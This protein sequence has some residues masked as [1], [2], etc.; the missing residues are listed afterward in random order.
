[1]PNSRLIKIGFVVLGFPIAVVRGSADDPA[2]QTKPAVAGVESLAPSGE[3]SRQSSAGISALATTAVD[4]ARRWEAGEVSFAGQWMTPDE[5]ARFLNQDRSDSAYQDRRKKTA[6]TADG[7]FKLAQWCREHDMPE[8]YR[9]HLIV[10][11]QL[12]PRDTRAHKA[13]GLVRHEGIWMSDADLAAARTRQ[14]AALK[15]YQFWKKELSE[16]RAGLVSG[17]L[18]VRQNAESELRKIRDPYAIPAMEEVSSQLQDERIGGI[19]VETLGQILHKAATGSLV[20]HAVWHNVASVR[21]AAIEQLRH[22]DQEHYVGDLIHLMRPAESGEVWITWRGGQAARVWFLQDYDRNYVIVN[23]VGVGHGRPDTMEN[24]T[25]Q[26][27]TRFDIVSANN[28]FRMQ[29]AY[30]ALKAVTGEDFGSDQQPWIQWLKDLSYVSP[31]EYSNPTRT[32]VL[33][34]ENVYTPGPIGYNQ[35]GHSCFVAGTPVW[36]ARGLVAIDHIQLGD[37]VLSKNV[38]TGE[39]GYQ[40]VIDRTIRRQKPTV[41]LQF[42]GETIGV[43]PRHPIWTPERDWVRA[44][45]LGPGDLVSTSSGSTPVETSSEGQSDYVYN[46]VVSGTNTYFVGRN[47]ILAHDITPIADV[48][49]ASAVPDQAAD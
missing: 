31:G 29:N 9:A 36:T 28:R 5:V 8:L 25:V 23:S 11:A 40:P 47:R 38:E 18:E 32:T 19:V 45:D 34:Y 17:D 16:I 33:S 14:A 37:L 21:G 27:R 46:L 49:I 30:S 39:L 48:R 3:S 2:S 15:G 43:T 24:R 6:D 1:M 4:S 26:N 42:E 7:H 13:L 35:L 22:R 10:A 12:D 41:N 20:R 44:R